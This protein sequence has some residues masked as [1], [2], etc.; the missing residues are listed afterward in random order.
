MGRGDRTKDLIQGYVASRTE[1]SN[2]WDLSQQ[3]FRGDI[4]DSD[5]IEAF[6]QKYETYRVTPDPATILGQLGANKG[7][8]PEDIEFLA[9][10]SADEFYKAFKTHSG[11]DLRRILYGALMF[12][13]APNANEKMK[14]I[15][16]AAVEALRKISA[17][18][19]MNARRVQKYGIDV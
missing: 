14:S 9:S 6:R 18:S 8:N 5:V 13:D 15:T 12:K 7:W 1:E 19:S 3:P 11:I 17:E 10:L 4:K 2:F 16:K